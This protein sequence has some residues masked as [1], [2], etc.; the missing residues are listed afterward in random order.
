MGWDHRDV[1]GAL[2]GLGRRVEVR[3]ARPALQPGSRPQVRPGPRSPLSNAM[4]RRVDLSLTLTM[5][6]EAEEAAVVREH[7]IVGARQHPYRL[8]K[9]IIEKLQ[10]LLTDLADAAD[11]G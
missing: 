7:Y 10:R 11:N 2:Y 3:P 5:H 1:E 8:R 6:L 4:A 9:P